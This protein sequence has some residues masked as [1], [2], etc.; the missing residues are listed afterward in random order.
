MAEDPNGLIPD[1]HAPSPAGIGLGFRLPLAQEFL[2]SEST[3]ADFIEIAPE[4]YLFCGGKRLRLLHAA[5]ERFPVVSHGLCG[6][7]SGSSPLDMEILEGL[8]VFLKEMKAAWYSDHLCLTVINGRALHELLPLRFCEETVI[9]A[10]GRIREIQDLLELPI[11]IENVSAY[12]TMP[13]PQ[14]SEHEFVSH[15][16]NEADCKLLLDINNVYV[17]S[18]NFGF[19]PD[20]YIDAL[21]LERVIQI[22]IAGHREDESGLRIDTHGEQIIDP[23]FKLLARTLPKLSGRVPILLERDANIPPLSELELEL[24]R[25]QEIAQAAWGANQSNAE[26]RL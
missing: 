6:D 21:P 1:Q 3:S 7:F 22:H 18:K 15:V 16:L 14:M 26:Q 23:V 25:L 8:K 12:L 5:R 11:A 2:A 13:D 17:N 24:R 10:A 20:A 9:R 19:D 4:N